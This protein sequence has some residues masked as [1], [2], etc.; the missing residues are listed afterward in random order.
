VLLAEAVSA[1]AAKVALRGPEPEQKPVTW[2][3]WLR[4]RYL[5]AIAVPRCDRPSRQ[6]ANQ[7]GLA[8]V[9]REVLEREFPQV[10]KS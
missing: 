2:W 8:R 5:L 3:R 6:P 1:V 7:L 4:S 9:I 10:V